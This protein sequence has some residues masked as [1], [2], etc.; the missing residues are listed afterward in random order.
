MSQG[1]TIADF[2]L[3]WIISPAAMGSVLQIIVGDYLAFY[4]HL[5]Q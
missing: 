3:T 2:Y 5:A 4:Q 1:H